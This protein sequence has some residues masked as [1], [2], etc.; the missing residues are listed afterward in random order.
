MYSSYDL[1]VIIPTKDRPGKVRRHLQSLIEQN[2]EIGR[3]IIVA[4]GDDIQDIIQLNI[5]FEVKDETQQRPERFSSQDKRERLR[6]LCGGEET[7]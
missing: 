5:L 1:A 3:V 6:F 4:S 2:C 7:S